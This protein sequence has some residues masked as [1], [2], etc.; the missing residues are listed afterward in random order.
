MRDYYQC[1]PAILTNTL[2]P[3]LGL[4]SILQNQLAVAL[5]ALTISP[6][7]VIDDKLVE[8]FN[9]D[10]SMWNCKGLRHCLHKRQ[11]APPEDVHIRYFALE[12]KCTW[13]VVLVEILLTIWR[14]YIMHEKIY[15]NNDM[16]NERWMSAK[17]LHAGFIIAHAEFIIA[18]QNSKQ[19]ADD[20]QV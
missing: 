11:K 2:V 4:S 5:D 7:L 18:S 15:K 12:C 8:V 17:W 6:F 9:G 13:Q 1:N 20:H 19:V 3:Q 16:H 14:Q 10:K